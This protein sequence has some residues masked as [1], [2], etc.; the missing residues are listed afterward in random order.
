MH[1]FESDWSDQDCESRTGTGALGGSRWWFGIM[2]AVIEMFQYSDLFQ[3]ASIPTAWWPWQSCSFISILHIIY[4][5]PVYLNCTYLGS[6]TH[7]TT[8]CTYQECIYTI[9]LRT[10]K[11]SKEI[12]LACKAAALEKRGKKKISRTGRDAEKPGREGSGGSWTFKGKKKKS[13]SVKFCL[14]LWMQKR[15]QRAK[16]MK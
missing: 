5:V 15:Y 16:Q 8:C 12:A 2:E 6:C 11:S 7:V 9:W 14:I 13:N 4:A 1:L 3:K 10:L